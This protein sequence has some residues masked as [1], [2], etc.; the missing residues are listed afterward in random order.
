MEGLMESYSR[1][2]K[3]SGAAEMDNAFNEKQDHVRLLSVDLVGEG[4]EVD[5][6]FHKPASLEDTMPKLQNPINSS[7]SPN[8]TSKKRKMVS[9]IIHIPLRNPADKNYYDIKEKDFA[10]ITD[11]FGLSDY[12]RFAQSS[13]LSFDIIPR[14]TTN[15]KKEDGSSNSKTRT[16]G[17]YAS[18][19]AKHFFGLYIH[20]SSTSN[21]TQAIF[22]GGGNI[23]QQFLDTFST[24]PHPL[25][26]SPFY[27]LLVMATSINSF[28]QNNLDSTRNDI[29]RLEART[30][31]SGWGVN[32]YEPLQGSFSELSNRMSGCFSS[33]AAHRRSVK[34]C[35]MVLGAVEETGFE[36]LDFDGGGVD[37]VV[38]GDDGV[39]DD[40]GG[41][42]KRGSEYVRRLFKDH[43][44][45][46]RRRANMQDMFNELLKTRAQNQITAVSHTRN[47]LTSLPPYRFHNVQEIVQIS[48]SLQCERTNQSSL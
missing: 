4:T 25:Y 2:Y 43:V 16:S 14:Y 42:G 22:C 5:L 34:L 9:R 12:M 29:L 21:L 10:R 32:V 1:M 7:P 31:C 13:G 24:L 3:E 6:M 47:L 45:V 38:D 18:V 40:D 48:L 20:Y 36:G 11:L 23:Y 8:P 37:G 27:I 28:N 35:L 39:V 17:F 44:T 46:I 19:Y 26:P 33:M 41:G 30:G 15:H